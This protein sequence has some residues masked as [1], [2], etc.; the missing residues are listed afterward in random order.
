MLAE[1]LLV[2][3]A[4]KPILQLH[5]LGRATVPKKPTAL[6]REWLPG[7]DVVLAPSDRGIIGV[8]DAPPSQFFRA[9]LTVSEGVRLLVLG[10][11][12]LARGECEDETTLTRVHGG[13]QL[14]D[15]ANTVGEIRLRFGRDTLPIM[16]VPRKLSGRLDPIV[17]LEQLLADVW[18]RHLGLIRR[19]GRSAEVSF[20]R[21]EISPTPIQTLMLLDRLVWT[22][23]VSESWDAT[24]AEPHSALVVERPVVA[25]DRARRAITHGSRGPWSVA[26]GFDQDGDIH[27][28]RDRRP[29][30]S[31]DTPPNQLAVRLARAVGD[32]SE[33]VAV[34][35]RSEAAK[36]PTGA[37][38]AWLERARGLTRRTSEIRCAPS[39]ADV[40]MTAPLALDAPSLVLNARCQ[41]QLRAWGTLDAGMSFNPAGERIFR[42]PLGESWRLFEYWC[43]FR[44][45]ELVDAQARAHDSQFQA[46]SD[47][48]VTGADSLTEGFVHKAH[49]AEGLT[50]ELLYNC[51]KK[52]FRS[53]SRLLRPDLAMLVKRGDVFLDFIVF[54]AK[55]RRDFLDDKRLEKSD[56]I[57]VMHGYRDALRRPTGSSGLDRP[58]WVF[59]LY[60]GD[61]AIAY[62]EGR[63]ADSPE[64]ALAQVA[65]CVSNPKS[66]GVGAIPAEP[67]GQDALGDIVSALLLAHGLVKPIGV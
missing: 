38:L 41:P 57:K 25:I 60:P 11:V 45:C 32:A 23:G 15:L 62:P 6:L 48:R 22:E 40:S 21:G 51:D 10:E 46:K 61:R 49:F 55:Y 16:V 50:V 14:L 31:T 5:E 8:T 43:W 63:A 7:A 35:I 58:R 54:D 1:A 36:K 30:R 28:A 17:A 4:G 27:R 64:L 18:R 29:S 26:A 9:P 67:R 65:E 52:E 66:G 33:R 13:L 44:L 34:Q 37:S 2:R 59:A 12:T 3:R 20:A 56:D 53:Y 19:V 42:D 24:L 39:L 47:S